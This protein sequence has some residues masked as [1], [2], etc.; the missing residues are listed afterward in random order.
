MREPMTPD[1]HHAHGEAVGG[2]AGDA[3]LLAVARRQPRPE[4]HADGHDHPERAQR[5]RPELD[6][7]EGRVG[8]RRQH[9]RMLRCRAA[10][11]ASRREALRRPTRLRGRRTRHKG[12]CQP[13]TPRRGCRRRSDPTCPGGRG[14]P[15]AGWRG[16]ARRSATARPGRRRAR[17]GG[18][19]RPWRPRAAAG[20]PPAAR[21]T[22]RRSSPRGRP[23]GCASSSPGALGLEVQHH[24]VLLAE[25][26]P[27]VVRVRR[28]RARRLRTGAAAA[29]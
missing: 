13:P 4:Q 26:E 16:R 18:C 3:V 2:V 7:G 23:G 28:R 17:S 12:S 24:A 15:G 8:D 25:P 11:F 10:G 21:R 9:E 22:P 5:Q 29:R 14:S 20:R 19:R 27:E 6:R 1:D